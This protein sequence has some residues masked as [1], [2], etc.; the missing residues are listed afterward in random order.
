M[1]V[2]QAPQWV[3]GACVVVLTVACGKKE[4]PPPLPQPDPPTNQASAVPAPSAIQG[5]LGKW[6]GP[7]GTYLQ[8]VAKPDAKY[9][10]VI[11][12]LDGERTFAGV[13]NIDHVYFERDGHQEKIRA[14]D[15][16]ATG[17]KW[18]AGK[19]KCLTIKR[20]EGYCRE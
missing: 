20:G 8:L 19:S 6:D 9:D 12:N 14:T 3:T 5:W 13:G 17:M 7:E 11:K 1:Q 15:G 2:R 10:V 18:L 4:A 16:N